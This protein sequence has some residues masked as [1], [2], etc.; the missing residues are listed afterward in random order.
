[1]QLSE[2]ATLRDGRGT[3]VQSFRHNVMAHYCDADKGAESNGQAKRPEI[4]PERW[5]GT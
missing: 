3:D 1:M 2:V 5:W 4:S